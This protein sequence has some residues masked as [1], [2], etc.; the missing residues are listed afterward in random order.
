[1]I[2]SPEE[3]AE[4]LTELATDLNVG[5]LMLLMHFGN[6]GKDLAA[7]NT[8]LFAEQVFPKLILGGEEAQEPIKHLLRR[9]LIQMSDLQYSTSERCMGVALLQYWE[10]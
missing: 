10:R 5:H 1:V 8:K 4:R 3:V 6:M 7:Y 9:F 2:G